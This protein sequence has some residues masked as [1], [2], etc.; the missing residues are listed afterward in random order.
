MADW[1]SE[2]ISGSFWKAVDNLIESFLN[3]V[4]E[5]LSQVIVQPT[6]PSKYIHNFDQYLKGVQFFAGGL[7]VIFVIWSVFRQLS[8][9]MYSDERSMGSYF[10]HITFAGALIYILPKAVTLVFLPINTALINFIG[11]VGIDVSA[12]DN[13]MQTV[14]GGIREEE[15]SRIMFLILIIAIVVFGIAGAIRYIETIIAILISPLVALSVINNGDGLQVWL[16][17]LIAI[18]FTQTIHFLILQIL[19]S[20]I[21]GV[22]NMTLMIILSIGTIAVGLRGP[23]ILRQYLYKTGTSSALVSSIGSVSRLGMMG[24]MIKR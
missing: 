16:R 19:L 18:V 17:E 11:S 7:L 15:I 14:W 4:Y 1:I 13:T 10:I 24:V 3:Y 22:E 9:V 6:E 20:I 8:G 2:I 12:I 21:G 23:Q 5:F